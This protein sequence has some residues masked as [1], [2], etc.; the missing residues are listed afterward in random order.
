MTSSFKTN[1]PSYKRKC[2]RIIV[3]YLT[4]VKHKSS[5]EEHYNERTPL[6]PLRKKSLSPPHAPSKSTSSRST[7]QTTSSSPS[8]SPTPTHVSPPSNIRFVI[9]MKL[10]HQELPPQHPSSHDLYVSTIDNWPPGLPNRYPVSTSSIHIESYKS[11]TAVRFDDDTGKIS[12]ITMN[13][14]EYHSDV[15]ARSQG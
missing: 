13:T 12:I 8:E 10:E 7:Y 5:S 2:V 14:K 15:L 9:P 6:T 11:P 4:Y 3:K 1:P